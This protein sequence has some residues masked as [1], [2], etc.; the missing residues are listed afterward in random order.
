MFANIAKFL[1]F[2]WNVVAKE[3][4]REKLAFVEVFYHIDP[5]NKSLNISNFSE[6]TQP[7]LT[8]ED[9]RKEYGIRPLGASWQDTWTD[10]VIGMIHPDLREADSRIKMFLGYK[11][12]N[13]GTVQPDNTELIDVPGNIK[14]SIQSGNIIQ[15]FKELELLERNNVVKINS[16]FYIPIGI[17]RMRP[18]EDY[19]QYCA[20][21]N[22]VTP[23]DARNY[24]LDMCKLCGHNVKITGKKRSLN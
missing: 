23:N 11:W 4:K 15:N 22:V 20:R 9:F 16:N 5:M 13:T 14:Q 10:Y 17:E 21:H 18:G 12:I 3:C 6:V 24:A 7:H 2:N 1:T 19:S 8:I